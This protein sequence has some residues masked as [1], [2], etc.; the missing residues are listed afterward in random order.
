MMYLIGN[1]GMWR[2]EYH[3]L[4]I[5]LQQRKNQKGDIEKGR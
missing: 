5:I 3:D 2:G 1:R 4:E